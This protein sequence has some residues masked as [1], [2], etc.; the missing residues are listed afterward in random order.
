MAILEETHSK[1]GAALPRAATSGR[2][3]L[4]FHPPCRAL[5]VLQEQAML[6]ARPM[7]SAPQYEQRQDGD[8]GAAA[9]PDFE[10]LDDELRHSTRVV[11]RMVREAPAIV[12]RLHEF[13]GADAA[14]SAP[15][16]KFLAAAELGIQT[17]REARVGRGGEVEALLVPRDLGARARARRSSARRFRSRDQGGEAERDAFSGARRHHPKLREEL[18]AIQTTSSSSSASTPRRS[19]READDQELVSRRST[20]SGGAGAVAGT[21]L[22]ASGR[23]LEQARVVKE[24]EDLLDRDVRPRRRNFAP[25]T[26]VATAAAPPRRPPADLHPDRPPAARR[27]ARFRHCAPS[28]R[29]SGRR[30]CS[31]RTISTS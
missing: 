20:L 22:A 27:T 2:C 24:A 3:L 10:T 1:L 8:G 23:S 30:C 16:E 5:Q 14:A 26:A 19:R 4:H 28:T 17:L 21:E 31:S 25:A 11:C 15:M 12:E 7:V 13:G 29:R 9:L 18:D 6:S